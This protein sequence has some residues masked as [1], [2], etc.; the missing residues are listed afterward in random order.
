MCGYGAE[1]AAVQADPPPP[2][3]D[4]D[5]GDPLLFLLSMILWSLENSGLG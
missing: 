3:N 4:N 5:P 1:I 2:L